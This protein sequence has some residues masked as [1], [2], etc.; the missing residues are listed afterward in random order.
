MKHSQHNGK[1]ELQLE[2][3]FTV[4]VV[5]EGHAA[6]RLQSLKCVSLNAAAAQEHRGRVNLS[7]VRVKEASDVKYDK[8]GKAYRQAKLLDSYGFVCGCM[9]W[10][11][12]VAMGNLWE[13][14]NTIEIMSAE[15]NRQDQRLDLRVFSFAQNVAA[16]RGFA[17]PRRLQMVVW[18]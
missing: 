4:T 16:V 7:L 11:D 18:K 5:P 17:V 10:G 12:I 1:D 2:E 8:N 6:L 14:D 13:R 15:V 3:N 9:V